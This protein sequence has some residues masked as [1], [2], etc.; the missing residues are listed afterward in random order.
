MRARSVAPGAP[1]SGA[2]TSLPEAEPGAGEVLVQAL[3]VGVCGTDREILAGEYGEAPPGEPR[4]VLGHESLGRVLQAPTDSGLEAGGLVVG[5]VRRPDPVPCPNCAVGEWDMCTN[6]RY[7]EHGIKGLHG[8]CRERYALDVRSV[9]ELPASLGETGVLAEPAS[10]LAKAWEHVEAIGRR[11]RWEP[12]RLLVTGAGPIGLLAALF[13][14]QR[15]LDVHVFDRH[16]E[17]PK[18]RLVGDLGGSYHVGRVE[19]ACH[20]ADVVMECTGAGQLVLD[21]MRCTAANGIVCLT[22]LSS[23]GRRLAVDVAALNKTMVLENDVVFGTV[24]ANRRHYEAGIAALAKADP[25]WLGRL[26]TRREPLDAWQ[27]ALEKRPEDVKT[28]IE[29]GS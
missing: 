17:G 29:L 26:V 1:G 6:G 7:T 15:G 28:V 13:G 2:L 25:A 10:V 21:A 14:V 18:P 9:V 22:G 5:I 4:L 8:F 19:D 24:N 16:T 23:G 27:A 12:R 11:A 20:G 3:A